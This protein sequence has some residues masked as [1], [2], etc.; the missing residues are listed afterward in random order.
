MNDNLHASPTALVDAC[1]ALITFAPGT[2]PVWDEFRA[3]FHPKA[4][5]GLRVFPEDP[6]VTIMDLD[7]YIIRQMREGLEQQGYSERV[8]NRSEVVFHD[9]AEVRVLF[10]MQFGDAKPHT[11]IDIFSLVR[12]DGRWYITS[13]VSD[14]LRPSEVVPAEFA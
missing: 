3:L 10:S 8:L 1:Y 5:L 9:I 7:R 12:S 11:A 4:V 6:S 13:I 14:I 2:E